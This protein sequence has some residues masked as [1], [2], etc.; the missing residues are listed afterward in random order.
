MSSWERP[1]DIYLDVRKP[2]AEHS[3][4]SPNGTAFSSVTTPLKWIE[5]DAFNLRLYLVDPEDSSYENVT[6]SAVMLAGKPVAGMEDDPLFSAQDFS[7]VDLGNDKYCLEAELDLNTEE[8]ISAIDAASQT[9]N[10]PKNVLVVVDVEVQNLTNTLRTTYRFW[11]NV[12][13]QSY[14]DSDL[15]PTP[16]PPS[17]PDPGDL[18]ANKSGAAALSAGTSSIEVDLSSHVLSEAPA[19]VLLTIRKPSADDPQIFATLAAVSSTA[20]TAHFSGEI[21]GAGYTINYLVI[22]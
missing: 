9:G 8:L 19:V 4:L 10:E 16:G 22:P 2:G 1:V 12:Y 17:Y 21:P 5:G 7:V 20:F 11:V 14:S 3:M 18:V 6:D 13:R 15:D